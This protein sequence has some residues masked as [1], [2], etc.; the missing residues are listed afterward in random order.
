MKKWTFLAVAILSEVTA[1]LALK[2]AVE[3]PVWLALSLG[4]YIVAFYCLG[5]VLKYG[6]SIG[7]AYGIWAAAGVS[8]TA[9][10][11]TLIYSEPL[12]LQMAIGIAVIIVGVLFVE[13]GSGHVPKK[14]IR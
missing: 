5:V 10:L 9:I 2:A 7:V 8:L 6:L 3:T 4:G 12:T 1:T 11:A 14:D 13:M